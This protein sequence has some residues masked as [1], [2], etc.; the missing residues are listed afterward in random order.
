MIKKSLILVW[1][2]LI[3]IVSSGCSVRHQAKSKVKDF[4]IFIQNMEAV[5][6]SQFNYFI[7]LKKLQDVKLGITE[8]QL[9][10]VIGSNKFTTRFSYNQVLGKRL[11]K[12]RYIPITK[13]ISFTGFKTNVTQGDGYTGYE[14]KEELGVSFF[15]YL[16]RLIYIAIN[17]R[18]KKDG[19]WIQLPDSSEDVLYAVNHRD[20]EEP[21]GYAETN[22]GGD[23]KYYGFVNGYL[24]EKFK[25]SGERYFVPLVPLNKLRPI[26]FLAKYCEKSYYWEA[27]EYEADLKK[28]GY[29]KLKAKLDKD[30]EKK[31]GYWEQK[32]VN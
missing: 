9:Y 7:E 23:S 13:T 10:Q 27:R 2:F 21:I 22:A 1:I 20:S 17:H 8:E 29:Y 5:H 32:S 28:S 30:F 15:F 18:E 16:E 6:T 4:N 3:S 26:D 24:G 11:R 19:K 12:M 14:S 31:S 25:N